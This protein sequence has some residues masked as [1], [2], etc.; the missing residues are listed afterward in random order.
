[1]DVSRM[2]GKVVTG[3][4]SPNGHG[5]ALRGAEAGGVAASVPKG[6]R[7]LDGP[8]VL[9]GDELLSRSELISRYPKLEHGLRPVDPGDPPPGVTVEDRDGVRV[10]SVNLHGGVPGETELKRPNENIKALRD[11][12]AYVQS[13]DADVVLVQ[14][15]RQSD[16]G[17]TGLPRQADILYHLMDADAMAFGAATESNLQDSDVAIGN[18]VFT[19]NGYEINRSANVDLRNTM[20][21]SNNDGE[22]LEWA[23]RSATVASIV[24]PSG[25]PALTAI[26]THLTVAGAKPQ[27]GDGEPNVEV[28]NDLLAYELAQI[29]QVVED[30]AEDGSFE[31][32]SARSRTEAT[33]SGYA[34]NAI[35]VGGDFN[36]VQSTIDNALDGATLVNSMDQLDEAGQEAAGIEEKTILGH[37]IRIDHLYMAGSAQA[38]QGATHWIDYSGNQ[39]GP[40]TDHAAVM[41]DITV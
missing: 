19:R 13:V 28:G 12:A 27:G 35:V 1:M 8:D 22:L 29:E 4:Y 30:I 37:D 15:L 7:N 26:S 38:V 41:W 32:H 39:D 40:A 17:D 14:E 10:V 6:A 11:I 9:E 23:N 18:A 3:T 34:S 2:V 24:D 25:T 20:P 21:D 31:Y 5:K 36:A 33:G 16:D